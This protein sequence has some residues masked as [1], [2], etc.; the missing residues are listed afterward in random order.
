MTPAAA[1]PATPGANAAAS[2][3]AVETL[4]HGRRVKIRALRP[5]DRAELLAAFGRVSARSI[6]RRFFVPKRRLS[7]AEVAYFMAVDFVS[8]VA[9]VAESEADGRPLIIGGVVGAQYGVGFAERL[10]AEQLRAG[11]ALLVLAVAVRIALGLVVTP[12][13]RFSIEAPP[14]D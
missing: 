6:S 2:Y 12:A 10:K 1:V 4:R 8:H 9:L 11:L 13:D 7:D 5:E 14:I 3:C